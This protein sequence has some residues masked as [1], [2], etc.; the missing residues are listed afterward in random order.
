MYEIDLVQVKEERE[1]QERVMARLQE[2]NAAFAAAK[3]GDSS[4]REREQALQK[5]ENAYFK[6][7]E[8][9]SNLDV[10][11]KFYNDLAKLVVRF[12]DECIGFL[13]QRRNEAEKLQGCVCILPA[14]DDGE[15]S[16]LTDLMKVTSQLGCHRSASRM[17]ATHVPVLIR[18]QFIKDQRWHHH[19]HLYH[20]KYND[21]STST[22]YNN[23][24]YPYKHSRSTTLNHHLNSGSSSSSSILG[25]WLHTR[26]LLLQGTISQRV[27]LPC[28]FNPCPERQGRGVRMLVSSLAVVVVVVVAVEE[29]ED[30][31]EL[32]AKEDRED[33]HEGE[34]PRTFIPRNRHA[35]NHHQHNNNNKH[36]QV[37]G[38]V[39]VKRNRGNGILRGGYISDDLSYY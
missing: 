24:S 37:M 18:Q 32:E 11:R 38:R 35:T 31:E 39:L 30:W 28:L 25:P 13:Q 17:K 7:K 27:H 3:K 1:E 36:N 15:V 22:N 23:S 26:P 12:R 19:R 10:G 33:R 2:A 6:Y 20:S 8:I 29:L 9:V 21:T 5:L 34:V 16:K 4:S 14:D